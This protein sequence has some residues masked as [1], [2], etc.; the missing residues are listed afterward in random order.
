[1]QA[2]HI[3]KVNDVMLQAAFIQYVEDMVAQALLQKRTSLSDG[4]AGSYPATAPANEAGPAN[5]TGRS[6]WDLEN[7]I[8]WDANQSNG[9]SCEAYELLNNARVN[10]KN[11][12]KETP[13]NSRYLATDIRASQA[14]PLPPTIELIKVD[15]GSLGCAEVFNVIQAHGGSAVSN[16]AACKWAI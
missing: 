4:T 5:T 10:V 9:L 8:I 6:Q 3:P 11:L 16:K 12:L 15:G 2:T 1:M 13:A 7:L 14:Q